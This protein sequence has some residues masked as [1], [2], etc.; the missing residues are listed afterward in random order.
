MIDVD[1]LISFAD[2]SL[3]FSKYEWLVR[4]WFLRIP[5]LA[6]DSFKFARA[7]SYGHSTVFHF[8]EVGNGYEADGMSDFSVNRKL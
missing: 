6:L 8:F 7:E 5:S 2:L 4:A 1:S 3:N